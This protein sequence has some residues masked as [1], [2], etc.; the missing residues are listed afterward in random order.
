MAIVRLKPGHV[1]PVW[2]GHPWVYAQ[3]IDR[4]EGKPTKGDEVS[5]VDPRGHLLGRGLFSP[6]CALPVRILVRDADTPLGAEFFR[7]RIARAAARRRDLGLPSESSS[8]S[9]STSRDT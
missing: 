4:V 7:E 2:A 1:Q 9:T 5:V 6:R 3:A 8:A